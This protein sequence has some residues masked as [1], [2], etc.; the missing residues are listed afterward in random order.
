MSK[1]TADRARVPIPLAPRALGPALDDLIPDSLGGDGRVRLRELDASATG[2]LDPARREALRRFIYRTLQNRLTRLPQEVLDHRLP[3]PAI[4]LRGYPLDWRTTDCL[5]KLLP[6]LPGDTDWTVGRY[7]TI[8]K[9]KAAS[10]LDVLGAFEAGDDISDE[11]ANASS[12]APRAQSTDTSTLAR[13]LK[14]LKSRLPLTAPAA[15]RA[16]VEL[17]QAGREGSITELVKQAEAEGLVVPFRIVRQGACTFVVAPEQAAGVLALYAA[18]VHV[19]RHWG[20]ASVRQ[21]VKHVRVLHGQTAGASGAGDATAERRFVDGRLARTVLSSLPRFSWL[22][23]KLGWFWFRDCPNR[24][25]RALGK[26][27]S[28]TTSIGLDVLQTALFRSAR[29]AGVA[30]PSRRAIESACAQL[31]GCRLEGAHVRVDAAL[32]RTEWLSPTE[33]SL[34]ELLERAGGSGRTS[35]IHRM[36]LACGIAPGTFWRTVRGSPIVRTHLSTLALVR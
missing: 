34:V 15:N 1:T 31:P 28:V 10:L 30:Q 9:F 6:L 2:A 11:A 17:G 3:S 23:R 33:L 13:C 32:D 18:A 25:V 36:A 29:P 22:D 14:D 7:L 5:R 35:T 8:A 20:L 26:V 21:I 24:L 27:F 16:I 4:V 12:S 19:V